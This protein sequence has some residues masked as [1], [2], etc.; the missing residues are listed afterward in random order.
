MAQGGAALPAGSNL[1]EI[2]QRWTEKLRTL[3]QG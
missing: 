3:I 2:V 1:G